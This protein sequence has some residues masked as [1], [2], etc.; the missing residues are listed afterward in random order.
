MHTGTLFLVAV[1][2][3]VQSD[4]SCRDLQ[5]ICEAQLQFAPKAAAPTFGG[6]KGVDTSKSITDMQVLPFRLKS[7][8]QLF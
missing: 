8:A 7:V 2:H 5:D 6:A 3:A 4:L 1:R